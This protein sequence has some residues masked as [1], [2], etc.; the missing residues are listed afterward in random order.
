MKLHSN[1][2]WLLTAFAA[3]TFVGCNTT[4][5]PA[6]PPAPPT[7]SMTVQ[8]ARSLSNDPVAQSKDAEKSL[9]FDFKGSVTDGPSKGTAL[10]GKLTVELKTWK[11]DI[12]VFMGG[13]VTSSAR[14]PARGVLL[15]D[16]I[17]VF[18]EID[19]K[20]DAW[21][22]GQG[23][24]TKEGGF[25][26]TFD[27]PKLGQDTGTWTA[28]PSTTPTPPPPVGTT[29]MAYDFV[30]KVEAGP[31]KG[32]MLEGKLEIMLEGQG[33]P[34]PASDAMPPGGEKPKAVRK[35]TGTLTL[36][37]GTKVPVKGAILCGKRVVA[38]FKLADDGSKLIF[39][40]GVIQADNS[41]KGPFAIIDKTAGAEAKASDVG[42]WTATPV[43]S[44]PTPPPPPPTPA[45]TP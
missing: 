3:T 8:E 9:S 35:F 15:K 11:S 38:V 19:A 13:L 29:T 30:A 39:G 26:G 32:T 23:K 25:E 34:K 21:I 41:I 16:R 45:T 31:S 10:E 18:L 14:Y 20:T 37:D 1:L 12:Q 33:D 24:A 5:P 28:T 43:T 27:G 36:K 22:I 6:T 2:R 17:F 40:E 44:T 42:T 7:T 4:T